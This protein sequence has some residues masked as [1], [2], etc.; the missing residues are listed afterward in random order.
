[1]YPSQGNMKQLADVSL[2]G[3]SLGAESSYGTNPNRDKRKRKS[4]L[5]TLIRIE[6]WCA[7]RASAPHGAHR[8]IKLGAED[9]VVSRR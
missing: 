1:M 7:E 3:W 8:E 5:A 2:A 9:V 6:F 4:V